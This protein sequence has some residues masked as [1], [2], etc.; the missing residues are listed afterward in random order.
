[1]LLRKIKTLFHLFGLC[2]FIL[3]GCQTKET[4]PKIIIDLSNSDKLREEL[5]NEFESYQI[6]KIKTNESIGSLYYGNFYKNRFYFVEYALS[7]ASGICAIGL[8]GEVLW[9]Y[10]KFGKGPGEFIEC[11]FS[12]LLPFSDQLVIYDLVQGKLLFLGLDGKFIRE[13]KI[14]LWLNDLCELN[15]HNLLLNIQKSEARH[16]RPDGQRFDL[17]IISKNGQINK[18]FMFHSHTLLRW[19]NSGSNLIPMDSTF[20]YKNTLDYNIYEINSSGLF[21]KWT[22][23]FKSYNADTSKLLYAT[24]NSD[25]FINKM[26]QGD[27]ETVFFFDVIHAK[28]S[29]WIFNNF[30]GSNILSIFDKQTS[31]IRQFKSDS[32]NFFRVHGIPFLGIFQS[33]NSIVTTIDAIDAYEDWQRRSPE[34][35]QKT[36]P[37]WQSL[38]NTINPLD[39]PIIFA[40]YLK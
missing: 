11:T 16:R 31:E 13:L 12:R 15:D 35:K 8:N 22:L 37:C 20:F 3:F 7:K 18:S 6:I 36:D 24:E 17:C 2:L 14:D 26:L 38:M 21:P 4:T 10:N 1:M 34:E 29:I 27:V 40:G 39:N 33:K 32:T 28:S 30:K 9:R 19:A 25:T 23:D 5:G